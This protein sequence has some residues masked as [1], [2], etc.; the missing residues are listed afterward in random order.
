VIPE[1]ALQLFC[2]TSASLFVTMAKEW[3]PGLV[4][5]TGPEDWDRAIIHLWGDGIREFSRAFP[6]ILADRSCQ[7]GPQHTIHLLPD[8]RKT[9]DKFENV[10]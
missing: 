8:T 2:S 6:H 4:T 1:R 9:G 3:E 7:S 10:A 5:I